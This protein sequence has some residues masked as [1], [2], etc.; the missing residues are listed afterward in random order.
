MQNVF[1]LLPKVWQIL[2]DNALIGTIVHVG[3]KRKPIFRHIIHR[4]CKTVVLGCH[5]AAPSPRMKTG[6]VVASIAVPMT[7]VKMSINLLI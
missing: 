6:L 4:D 5:E 2:M 1:Q 7:V 3:E